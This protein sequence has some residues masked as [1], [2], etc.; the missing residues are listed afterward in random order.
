MGVQEKI[1]S[2]ANRYGVNPALALA[3]ARQE[4]G[5]NQTAVSSSGAV[6]IMQLMPGTAS[7]LGVD[8]YNEDQNIDGGIRY[9]A[10]QLRRF[11]SNEQALAAYNFGPGAVS[12]GLSWPAE[13]RNYVSRVL[14]YFGDFGGADAPSE[15]IQAEVLPMPAGLDDS[16]ML[17]LAAGLVGAAALWWML[18]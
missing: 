11:G 13:T 18:A 4:S 12:S 3:V 9:L 10:Q 6:G 15:P 2:A 17:L 5:F 16:Q 7:D 14:S 1:I 8:R